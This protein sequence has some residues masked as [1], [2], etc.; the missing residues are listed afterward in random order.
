MTS[1]IYYVC[2]MMYVV[3][4]VVVLTCYFVLCRNLLPFS[5]TFIKFVSGFNSPGYVL[6]SIFSIALWLYYVLNRSRSTTEHYAQSR[7]RSFRHLCFCMLHSGQTNVAQSTD[8]FA[9]LLSFPR[10]WFSD[11]VLKS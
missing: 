8:D 9:S 10:T 7:N 6:L 3:C 11:I 1:K 5:T 4:S 2:R